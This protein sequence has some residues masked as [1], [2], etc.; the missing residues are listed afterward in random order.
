MNKCTQEIFIYYVFKRN[1]TIKSDF[2]S[3]VS[4]SLLLTS[5][6]SSLCYGL[7][8]YPVISLSNIV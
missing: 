2:L 3:F 5:V 7:M 6:K 8:N 1:I 4:K